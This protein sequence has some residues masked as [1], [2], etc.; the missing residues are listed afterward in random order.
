MSPVSPKPAYK[1]ACKS[2]C[3]TSTEA[4]FEVATIAEPIA[5]PKAAKL[6]KAGAVKG[7][8][9]SAARDA[10]DGPQSGI[11]AKGRKPKAAAT[12]VKEPKVKSSKR[13]TKGGH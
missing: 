2:A 11:S 13:K 5:A 1:P 7:K 9:K 10:K 4:Q 12:R 3:Q 6:G 8:G